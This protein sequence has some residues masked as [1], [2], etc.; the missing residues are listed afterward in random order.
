MTDSKLKEISVSKLHE[1]QKLCKKYIDDDSYLFKICHDITNSLENKGRKWLV[2][3]QKLKDT[4]TNEKRDDIKDIKYAK[5][6]ANKLKVIGI[7]DIDNPN[8]TSSCI[9]NEYIDNFSSNI[10]RKL[11][12]TYTVNEIVE[13]D[14]YDED[15]NNVCS[16]GIH[17]FKTLERAYYYKDANKNHKYTG[18][19]ADWGDSGNKILEGAYANGKKIGEWRFWCNNEKIV[20][21]TNFPLDCY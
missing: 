5:C 6:R 1:L 8:V 21:T 9:V 15:I 4:K 19:W 18:Y 17:Y 20:L 13:P 2:I 12:T 7:I 14:K 3:M 11:K 10:E 16:S